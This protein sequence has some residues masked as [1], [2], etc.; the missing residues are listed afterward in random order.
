MQK[1]SRSCHGLG[2]KVRLTV[3]HED[4]AYA[5]DSME[6]AL[7]QIER[8]EKVMSLYRKDGQLTRLNTD[9][10]LENADPGLLEV[11]S[12]AQN[13]SEQTS[14][15]FD[16]TV[17][18]LWLAYR[19]ASWEGRLPS[20]AEIETAR[21]AVDWRRIKI[22]DST[23]SFT[24]PKTQVSLN[25]IA[26]GYAADRVAAALRAD[27]ICHALI[28]TGE[29]HSVGGKRENLPWRVGIQHPRKRSAVLERASLENRCLS[30]SGDY[31]SRFSQ[32]FS[33]HHIFR[34]AS[35][36]SPRELA[37]VSVVAPTALEADALSTACMVMGAELSTQFIESR[38]NVDAFIVKKTGEKIQTS[39]FPKYLTIS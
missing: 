33:S 34:P 22:E 32:D 1:T 21:G 23:V 9:G 5:A 2:A 3:Y 18:P 16:V 12:Y 11:L 37:S 38:P 8:I 31:E 4:A 7:T 10:Y 28:D 36:E 29:I 19:K 14:G 25:G 24:S 20:P 13:L 27:G 6:R 30:T 39:G 15:A 26:Q 17:Q 35:G